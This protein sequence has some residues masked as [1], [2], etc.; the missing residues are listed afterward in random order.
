MQAKS[1]SNKAGLKENLSFDESMKRRMK[2]LHGEWSEKT[3]LLRRC[4]RLY[5]LYERSKESTRFQSTKQCFSLCAPI[6]WHL[7]PPPLELKQHLPALKKCRVRRT[8]KRWTTPSPRTLSSQSTRW[9]ARWSIV[10]F[11]AGECR[12]HI[13]CFA[14]SANTCLHPFCGIFVF[15]DSFDT[16]S[17]ILIVL[18]RCFEG[19]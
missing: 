17:N 13:G 9:P 5:L 18:F 19:S 12:R 16:S 3:L 11:A 14:A 2:R 15:A 1:V 7:L 6:I 8:R 4:Q 10:S